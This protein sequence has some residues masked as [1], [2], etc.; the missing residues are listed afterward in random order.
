MLRTLIVPLDGSELAERALPYA[1]RLAASRRGRVVLVRAALG[2]PPSGT[3]WER[4]QLAVVDEAQAYLT[5]VAERIGS[6]VAVATA[7]PYGTPAREILSTVTEF[8]ADAVVM[9]THGRTGLAHLLNGSVAEA[10]LAESH[11]PV[12]LVHARPGEA[13]AA[14]FDPVAARI[15]VPL[16]GSTFAEAALPVAMDALGSAGE[17][18]LMTCMAPPERVERDDNGRVLAYLDQQE[19]ASK[20]EAYDYLQGIIRRLREPDPDV[21]IAVDI[22][23]GDPA[24]GI[25]LAAA[26]R[27]A[28]LVVMATHG[29]TGLQ[30][31]VSGSIAGAVLRKGSTPVMLVHPFTAAPVAPQG[32]P[33]GAS[34]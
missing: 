29:R 9:A 17:L 20:R 24:E 19:E 11:V 22:R 16:D 4:Q 15:I 6:R 31:A 8:D 12:F 27:V 7:C 1:V 21:H 25:V 28:D 26:D 32:E 3:D 5:S 14:P 13:E 34:A 30:R 33:V 2:P 18:V 23:I 10:V